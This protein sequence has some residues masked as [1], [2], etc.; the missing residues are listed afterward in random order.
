M[1]VCLFVYLLLCII[2]P[3]PHRYTP[4]NTNSPYD[5]HNPGN[6]YPMD[7]DPLGSSGPFGSNTCGTP[8]GVPN[9][10]LPPPLR[11][12]EEEKKSL[13]SSHSGDVKQTAADKLEVEEGPEYGFYC[14]NPWSYYMAMSNH[15]RVNNATDFLVMNAG[16]NSL[17]IDVEQAL[18]GSPYILT[19]T[20][21]SL[22]L[23]SLLSLRF[24]H[25]RF[26]SCD[27]SN[28][29]NSLSAAIMCVSY[30]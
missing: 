18:E 29:N 15:V 3:L 14:Y 2:V 21:L 20:Q 26:R 8:P 19:R 1:Y 24:N 16:N 11:R 10:A 22:S 6:G 13:K 9:P 30:K 28:P 7:C 17:D 12:E 27:P 25:N 23:L 5:P 4:N